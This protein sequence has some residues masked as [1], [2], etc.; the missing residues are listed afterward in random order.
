MKILGARNLTETM[1]VQRTDRC[2]SV[3]TQNLIARKTWLPGFV[4]LL[5]SLNVWLQFFRFSQRWVLRT[6]HRVVLWVGLKVSE[7]YCASMFR[8]EAPT[9]IREHDLLFGCF[10]PRIQ[11]GR[12]CILYSVFSPSKKTSLCVF[13]PL[14]LSLLFHLLVSHPSFILSLLPFVLTLPTFLLLSIILCFLYVR[15]LFSH[16]RSFY[17]VCLLPYSCLFLPPFIPRS[18]ALCQLAVSTLSFCHS[19]YLFTLQDHK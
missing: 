6:W 2:Y 1:Y 11:T 9:F 8:G 15:I 12:T 18:L 5:H 7:I 16:F 3:T 17:F 19:R 13:I 10:V 4:T 14:F